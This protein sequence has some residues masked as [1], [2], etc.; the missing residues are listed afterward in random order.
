MSSVPSGN[1]RQIVCIADEIDSLI[2]SKDSDQRQHEGVKADHTE[3]VPLA[4]AAQHPIGV[5]G[6]MPPLYPEAKA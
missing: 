4:N 6:A 1:Q 3:W 5:T 2:T